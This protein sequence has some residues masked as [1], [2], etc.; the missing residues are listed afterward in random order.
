MRDKIELAEI[1][2]AFHRKKMEYFQ[3]EIEI[4]S[5]KRQPKGYKKAKL[6]LKKLRKFAP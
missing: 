6:G 3:E 5:K 1:N 4:L 2:E